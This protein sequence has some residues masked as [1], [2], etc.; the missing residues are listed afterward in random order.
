MQPILLADRTGTQYD[1]LLAAFCR[2]SVRLSVTLRILSLRVCVQ[3]KK[4]HQRVPS[5]Q[6]PISPV[7]HCH[8]S[9]VVPVCI[10]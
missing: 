8:T 9:A 5:R 2:P 6:V 4:L 7:R 1:R 3:G 10:V